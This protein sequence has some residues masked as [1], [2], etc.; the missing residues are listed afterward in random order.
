MEQ[1]Q[2][3]I[4]TEMQVVKSLE[5]SN[6]ALLQGIT[7]E[8][9]TPLMSTKLLLNELQLDDANRT[10]IGQVNQQMTNLEKLIREILFVT[11]RKYLASNNMKSAV[12][13]VLDRV[14]TNYD[15]LL[16]DK[17]LTVERT[18]ETEFYMKLDEKMLEKILSNLVSN[19]IH[20]TVER[21]A[22]K[23]YVLADRIIIANQFEDKGKINWNRIGEPFM[24]FGSERGTGL[25]IYIIKTILINTPYVFTID[26]QA[27]NY[28]TA[29]ISLKSAPCDGK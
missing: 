25:G 22:I 4:E 11:Q 9:K 10:V 7:H 20:Y 16:D 15:V 21:T 8:M 3:K 17:Q 27:N 19:A 1:S 12:S 14:I 28:F 2:R 13:R 18:I 24:A 5:Q 29:E 23:I 26:H 6:L